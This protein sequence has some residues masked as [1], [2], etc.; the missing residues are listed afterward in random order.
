M[1][2][3]TIKGV[4]YQIKFG[5]QAIKKLGNSLGTTGLDDTFQKVAESFS[6]NNIGF[7]QLDIVGKMTLYAAECGSG[8]VNFDEDEAVEEIIRNMKIFKVV[9][10]SFKEILPQEEAEKGT[11]ATPAKKKRR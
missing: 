2:K 11:N 6:G 10:E 9:M 3:I 1:R 4:D 5:Y 8:S 7:D